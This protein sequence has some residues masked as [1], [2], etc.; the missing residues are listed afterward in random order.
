M[1]CFGSFVTK[2]ND[3]L[4]ESRHESVGSGYMPRAFS[5]CIGLSLPSP[6]TSDPLGW[7]RQDHSSLG[8]E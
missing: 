4:I 5:K 7:G 1:V 2:L 6:S 3:M 8:F